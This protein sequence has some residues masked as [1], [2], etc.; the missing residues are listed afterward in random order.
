MA[1]GV[2]GLPDLITGVGGHGEIN[3]H[4]QCAAAAIA[5]AVG[6]DEKEGFVVFVGGVARGRGAYL[7]NHGGQVHRGQIGKVGQF[8]AIE[9]GC[10]LHGE[11]D[12][13]A[14]GLAV[15]VLA[16]LDELEAGAGRGG[17]GL[18]QVGLQGIVQL[19]FFH[20][21]AAPHSGIFEHKPDICAVAGSA[22]DG[23]AG[24]A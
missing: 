9:C 15:A 6:A 16:A 20:R 10:I 4:A 17:D 12:E 21:F 19:A 14:E 7:G 1:A 3:G 24:G 18:L 8:E 22:V 11:A 2:G 5:A 13:E 23:F